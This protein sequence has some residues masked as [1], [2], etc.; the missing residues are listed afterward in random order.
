MYARTRMSHMTN[1][2]DWKQ[3]TDYYIPIYLGKQR[4]KAHYR[5]SLTVQHS[6]AL[7]VPCLYT[8][9]LWLGSGKKP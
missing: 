7:L 9:R 6:H 4:K 1:A 8:N 5:H 3:I 2:Y